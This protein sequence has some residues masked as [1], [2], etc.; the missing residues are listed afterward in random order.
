MQKKSELTNK[1]Y[2]SGREHVKMNSETRTHVSRG[3]EGLSL[4]QLL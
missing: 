2:P 4:K 3:Q 1:A